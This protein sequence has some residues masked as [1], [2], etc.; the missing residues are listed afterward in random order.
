M[1]RALRLAAGFVWWWVALFWLWLLVAGDWNRVELVGAA[2]AGAAGAILA[3]CG[4]QLVGATVRPASG[5]FRGAWSVPVAILVD[6]GILLRCLVRR[7]VEGTFVVRRVDLRGASER[8]WTVLVAGYSPNAY[9][10]DV[11]P[12]RG[13]AL[14]HDLV[15]RRSSESPIR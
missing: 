10:V 8:A 6:A 11:D 3:V 9:V 13:E 5:A 7:D 1:E 12:E 15:P 14:L 2:C 4:Q